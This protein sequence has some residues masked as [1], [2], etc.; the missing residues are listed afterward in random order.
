MPANFVVRPFQPSDA[1]AVAALWN[2][3]L[4]GSQPWNEPRAAIR[5]KL[6]ADDGLFFVG[7]RHGRIVATALAGYDGVRG[8]IYSL[9]VD[10]DHRR[11]G[12]GRRMIREA[13]QALLARGCAKINLQVRADNA[14]VVAFYER[15]GFAVEDRV[16][17]GKPLTGVVGPGDSP[18]R[19]EH[20]ERAGLTVR[21]AVADDAPLLAEMNRQ[22]IDGEASRNPMTDAELQERMRRWLEGEWRSVVFERDGGP[23]GYALFQF[24]NDEYRPADATV[25]L[26]QFFIKPEHRGRGIGRLAYDAVHRQHFG[27]A[28]SIV[29]DVLQTNPRAHRFWESLG[30]Q[31]YCATLRRTVDQ[32]KGR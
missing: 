13:E 11:L 10:A 31:P 17:L 30:F 29:L 3:A 28:T 22:L 20:A 15:C 7:E 24:R 8:W 9:A 12:I 32:Q 4:P 27:D 6:L 14:E 25:Y 21:A 18:S 19:V 1:D 5:R 26:R 23:V 2:E 16:S